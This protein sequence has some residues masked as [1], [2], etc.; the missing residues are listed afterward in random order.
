M[1][2]QL[3]PYRLAI[4]LHSFLTFTISPPV[5]RLLPA[6]HGNDRV[7]VLIF[8]QDLTQRKNGDAI[9]LASPF[10]R[11]QALVPSRYVSTLFL[12]AA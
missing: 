10:R 8:P 1:L 9:P 7:L 6:V 4:S 3:M 11:E 5:L 2:A 12:S